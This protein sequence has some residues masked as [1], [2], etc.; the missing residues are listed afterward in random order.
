MTEP[1]LAFLAVSRLFLLSLTFLALLLCS[2]A[3]LNAF[4]TSSHLKD[5][6]HLVPGMARLTAAMI[7]PAFC[8]LHNTVSFSVTNRLT[9]A[10]RLAMYSIFTACTAGS[11]QQPH[12]HVVRKP[13]VLRKGFPRVHQQWRARTAPS[14]VRQRRTDGVPTTTDSAHNSLQKW[15]SVAKKWGSEPKSGGQVT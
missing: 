12:A 2:L 11:N 5:P 8:L 4:L 9:R 10:L 13:P 7:L 3:S 1:A 6:W 15:G 14:G